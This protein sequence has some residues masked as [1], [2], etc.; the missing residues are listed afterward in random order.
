MCPRSA[1]ARR[2]RSR[3]GSVRINITG[4]SLSSVPRAGPRK[5]LYHSIWKPARSHRGSLPAFPRYHGRAR[6]TPRC[7]RGHRRLLG[8]R[9]TRRRT[10]IVGGLRNSVQA[11]TRPSGSTAGTTSRRPRPYDCSN[12][13]ALIRFA[14]VLRTPREQAI[15][16]VARR[17]RGRRRRSLLTTPRRQV[18]PVRPSLLAHGVPCERDGP[19]RATDSRRERAPWRRGAPHQMAGLA[20][21]QSVAR[22]K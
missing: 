9:P 10:V 2:S 15:G 16:A 13:T 5:Y 14:E 11:T 18:G 1:A 17:A 22:S 7:Q 21:S 6:L 12:G 4:S 8:T 3:N 19:G 20:C